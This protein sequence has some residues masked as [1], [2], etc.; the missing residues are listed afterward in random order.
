MERRFPGSNRTFT[1]LKGME[2]CGGDMNIAATWTVTAQE[3]LWTKLEETR[4]NPLKQAALI[5]FDTLFMILFRMLNVEEAAEKVSKKI[6]IPAK[7]VI[8]P[9][10]EL[11]MDVDKPHQLELLVEDLK[12][13]QAA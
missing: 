12:K 10:A 3:G 6:G 13:Q 9:Y 2:V 5:G 4:K 11:A 8:C 7:G 1:K